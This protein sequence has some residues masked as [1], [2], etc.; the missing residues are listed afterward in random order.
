[1]EGEYYENIRIGYRLDVH[2]EATI[3]CL[4][5]A[6]SDALVIEGNRIAPHRAPLLKPE[7][8][9]IA[10][11]SAFREGIR[12]STILRSYEQLFFSSS[13]TV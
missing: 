1:M 9:E 7:S 5:A 3:Y 12:V 4:D 10:Y 6:V 13:G 2:G 11:H 8:P